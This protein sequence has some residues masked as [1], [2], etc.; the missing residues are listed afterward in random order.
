VWDKADAEPRDSRQRKARDVAL[1]KLAVEP[2]VVDLMTA[3]F[4]CTV[5]PNHRKKKITYFQHMSL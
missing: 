1:F 3:D 2:L 5:N 4:H